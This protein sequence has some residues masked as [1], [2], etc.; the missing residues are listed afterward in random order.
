MI[1]WWDDSQITVELELEKYWHNMTFVLFHCHETRKDE[2][3]KLSKIG[4]ETSC[5]KQPSITIYGW[6]L[7]EWFTLCLGN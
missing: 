5:F 3:D 1:P 7:Q 6:D 2:I 4:A